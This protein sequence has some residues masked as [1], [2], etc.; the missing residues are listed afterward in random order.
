MRRGAAAIRHRAWE[1]SAV[2]CRNRSRKR[3]KPACNTLLRSCGDMFRL[4][5]VRK[6]K[7]PASSPSRPGTR[8]T[9]DSCCMS[10]Y[11]RSKKAYRLTHATSGLHWANV[12][13]V[14]Q[15][16]SPERGGG[17]RG[18]WPDGCAW[19]RGRRR[20]LAHDG[21]KMFSCSPLTRRRYAVAHRSGR[22]CLQ[23]RGMIMLPRRLQLGEMAFWV[24]RA[25][26]RWNC[27]PPRHP[28]LRPRLEP[29]RSVPGAWWP[30]LA[31]VR[32]CAAGGGFPRLTPMR[33]S[34]T[35][36]TSRRR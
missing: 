22:R 28:G 12:A 17:A 8:N 16:A 35:A 34:S 33:S 5:W 11:N 36:I 2:R 21:V 1:Q 26:S 14:D 27:R 3:T 20:G 32:R 7:S 23:A 4:R 31:S 25:I 13:W 30:G 9:S 6:W 10:S 18:C 29:P 19:L 15:L 24:A